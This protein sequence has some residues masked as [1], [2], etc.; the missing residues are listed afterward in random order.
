MKHRLIV[1]SAPPLVDSSLDSILDVAKT[2]LLSVYRDLAPLHRMSWQ[3]PICLSLDAAEMENL[4][5]SKNLH[6]YLVSTEQGYL[7]NEQQTQ[8]LA[9]PD[10]FIPP[11]VLAANKLIV[12]EITKHRT[13]LLPLWLK[14]L[15]NSTP[16]L[17][18]NVFEIHGEVIP[19]G[20]QEIANDKIA[21]EELANQRLIS[22]L[23]KHV[24]S[25]VVVHD[26]EE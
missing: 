2:L 23:A 4:C 18:W 24:G 20:P 5:H 1:V 19:P 9:N 26:S 14:V 6:V 12:Q 10:I 22:L 7:L 11:L 13:E 3:S 16:P 17:L 15:Q 8:V 25:F 21:K